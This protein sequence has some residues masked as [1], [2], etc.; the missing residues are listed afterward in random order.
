MAVGV[1]QGFA[2]GS[3]VRVGQAI[4]G[5]NPNWDL[6]IITL[7]TAYGFSMCQLFALL[8]FN[9]D[10]QLALKIFRE[11]RGCRGQE[12]LNPF[13]SITRNWSID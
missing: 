11:I 12:I 10:E 5:R 4:S 2:I 3:F 9:R 1:V 8:L 6:V 13:F 7:Y